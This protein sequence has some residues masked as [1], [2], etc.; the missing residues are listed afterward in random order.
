MKLSLR[1][2]LILGVIIFLVAFVGMAIFGSI[3]I[4]FWFGVSVFILNMI[5]TSPT[6]AEWDKERVKRLKEKRRLEEERKRVFE[7]YKNIEMAKAEGK[8]E[9]ELRGKDKFREGKRRKK[10]RLQRLKELRRS[11]GFP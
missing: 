8:A 2:R 7:E 3:K 5:F 9:G 11:M 10:E 1:N 6:F 4:G